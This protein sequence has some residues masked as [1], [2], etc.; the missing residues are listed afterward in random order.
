MTTLNVPPGPKGRLLS[1]NIRDMRR[2]TLGFF[3]RCAREFGDVA[4]F[5]VGFKRIFLVS[6]PK[7]IEE[8]LV[9]N[10]KNFTKHFG[11]RML[12]STLG[13][14]LLTSEGDFWLRQR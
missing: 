11:I 3:A 7:L 4:S 13:N 9:T 14:G 10:A 5:R 8:V 1:G 6:H 12:R 2:D